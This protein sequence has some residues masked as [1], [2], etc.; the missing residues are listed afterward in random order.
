MRLNINTPKGRHHLRVSIGVFLCVIVLT[1]YGLLIT[2][3]E[4]D[5]AISR[6]NHLV[7]LYATYTDLMLSDI[8]DM[9]YRVGMEY[10]TATAESQRQMLRDIWVGRQHDDALIHNIILLD[11]DKNPVF[12]THDTPAGMQADIDFALDYIVWGTSDQPIGTSKPFVCAFHDNAR[13]FALTHTLQNARGEVLGYARATINISTV[14]ERYEKLASA[15]DTR[16]TLLSA[17]GTIL[18]RVP[19]DDDVIGKVSP[20]FENIDSSFTSV[21][22]SSVQRAIDGTLQIFA[23]QK[24]ERYSIIVGGTI[25]YKTFMMRLLTIYLGLVVIGSLTSFIVY[26]FSLQLFRSET[27]EKTA[28]QEEKLALQGQ[29]EE[30]L[31]KRIEAERRRRKHEKILIQQ[32]KMA[33]MG[34]MIG[35]IA[36]QWRQP[37]NSIGLYV[38]D[39][40]DAYKYGE[41]NEE[42]IASVVSKTM[43]QLHFMSSTINDFRNFFKPDKLKDEFDLSKIVQN[44][45]SLISSQ[46]RSHN[47][48]I[49]YEI[50]PEPLW[51][52][53]YENELGQAI[54]NLLTNAKDALHE[55][56]GDDK[57]IVVR[58]RREDTTAALEV[59]DNGGGISETYIDRVFEP[60]FTTKEQGKG[61]GIGLY[62]TKMIVEENMHGK[63]S[64]YNIGGGVV[65]KIELPIVRVGTEDSC[66]LQNI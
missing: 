6:N 33:S 52:L 16:I 60:Y 59:E 46:L 63:L 11:K 9:I 35:A 37:L 8:D 3:Q 24:S 26:R 22:Q 54:L 62:M 44:T 39:L 36:H 40:R 50:P 30:A 64:A 61:T 2:D 48:E 15:P 41:L 58:L 25:S 17:D 21:R 5:R 53:G 57:K 49:F 4:S 20:V 47:I 51:C 38:Q 55:R 29:V 10:F 27:S 28:N 13:I 23:L 19:K 18:V 14:E 43:Q 32:S 42:Y 56:H 65:F 34:E 66:N 12:A 1:G 7:S 31:I 45:I